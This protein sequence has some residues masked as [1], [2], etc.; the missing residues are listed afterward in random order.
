MVCP[1]GAELGIVHIVLVLRVAVARRGAAPL[2]LGTIAGFVGVAFDRTVVRDVLHV[3][4]VGERD[5][6]PPMVALADSSL[7]A[8]SI[9]VAVI[10]T[11]G[12]VEWLTVNGDLRVLAAP[13]DV[14]P[15]A[16]GPERIVE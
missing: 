16:S 8:R 10:L 4:I 14:T 6:E 5:D 9:V 15:P 7:D 2:Q 12:R 13:L 3:I 11:G 1:L